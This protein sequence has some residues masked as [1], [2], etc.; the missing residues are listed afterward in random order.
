MKKH[1]SPSQ[2][3][4]TLPLWNGCW[5]GRRTYSYVF[6]LIVLRLIVQYWLLYIILILILSFKTSEILICLVVAHR[7]AFRSRVSL[8]RHNQMFDFASNQ[9][10]LIFKKHGAVFFLLDIY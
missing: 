3:G 4:T 10:L 6:R 5:E 7:L 8:W 2:Q 1:K 9:H